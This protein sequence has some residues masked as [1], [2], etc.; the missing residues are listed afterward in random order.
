[1]P[2]IFD[3]THSAVNLDS[4]GTGL[5]PPPLPAPQADN[6][7]VFHEADS[8][9]IAEQT[10]YSIASTIAEETASFYHHLVEADRAAELE[11]LAVADGWF[12]P[13]LAA[14]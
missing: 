12:A 6:L 3:C 14:F 4:F 7:T 10:A 13:V 5:L 2:V 1:M 8:A 9:S 11:R